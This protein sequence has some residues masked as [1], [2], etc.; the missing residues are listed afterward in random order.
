LRDIQTAEN[1]QTETRGIYRNKVITVA[2]ILLTYQM[3]LATA[4][5]GYCIS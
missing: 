1:S 4:G 2:K 3:V 5:D